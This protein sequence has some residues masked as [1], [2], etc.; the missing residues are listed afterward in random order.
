MGSGSDWRLGMRAHP[1]Q[2]IFQPAELRTADASTRVHMLDVSAGGARL[3]SA[4]PLNVGA[5]V[6]LLWCDQQRKA[7]VAWSRDQRC[8]IRFDVPLNPVQVAALF[9]PDPVAQ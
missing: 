2:K 9:G 1:R 6:V 4:L 8:G 7:Q 5:D 3:H